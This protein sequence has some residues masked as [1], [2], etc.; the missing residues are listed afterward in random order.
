MSLY[1]GSDNSV[2]ASA[3]VMQAMLEANQAGPMAHLWQRSL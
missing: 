1:F 2:G 3:P